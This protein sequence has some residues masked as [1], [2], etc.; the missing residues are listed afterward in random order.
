MNVFF[1]Q[2]I[3]IK[4]YN[5]KFENLPEEFDNYKIVQLTDIHSIRTK[6]Q[7]EQIVNKIES[8]NPDIIFITGD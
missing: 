3:Y 6:E 1:N 7:I 8:Q 2:G 4:K 5:L